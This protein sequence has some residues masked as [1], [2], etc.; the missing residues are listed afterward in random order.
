VVLQDQLAP[1]EGAVRVR[2]AVGDHDVDGVV[3]A[4]NLETA[5]VGAGLADVAEDEIVA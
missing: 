1:P 4:A 5:R 3:L 2:L